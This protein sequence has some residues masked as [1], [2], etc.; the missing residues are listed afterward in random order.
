MADKL[1]II[2]SD[3]EIDLSGNA[4]DQL[5]SW[6]PSIIK[7][8]S[9]V[10]GLEPWG[11]L[12]TEAVL[13]IMPDQRQERIINLIEVLNI[14]FGHLAEDVTRLKQRLHSPEGTDLLEEALIQ[15]ASALS[16]ERIEYIASLLANSLS[17]D[18]LEHAGKK[19]LFSLLEQISDPEIILLT[20]HSILKVVDQKKFAETHKELLAPI[21]LHHRAPK[22]EIERAALRATYEANLVKLGLLRVRY[23]TPRKG[24]LPEFDA[25]TGTLK[26]QGYE[27]TALGHALLRYI[28]ITLSWT[29][30]R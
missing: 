13:K 20:Y 16:D 1:S 27:F 5:R 2:T 3:Q 7:A 29:P 19:R 18:D 21:L 28:G 12:M 22:E 15:A 4:R 26:G 24:Q 9:I 8:I 14:R 17:H 23:S 10:G 6:L 25:S 11:S 30:I